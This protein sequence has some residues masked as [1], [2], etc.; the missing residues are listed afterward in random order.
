MSINELSL[1]QLHMEQKWPNPREPVA[2]TTSL[3]FIHYFSHQST[4]PQLHFMMPY[5]VPS[6][7]VF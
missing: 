1:Q 5:W 2:P 6:A 7:P 3:D 4:L